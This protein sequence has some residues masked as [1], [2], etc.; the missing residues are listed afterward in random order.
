MSAGRYEQ[1]VA[2]EA[3]AHSS[4]I[5]GHHVAMVSFPYDDTPS[6]WLQYRIVVRNG[7]KIFQKELGVPASA[8]PTPA[9]RLRWAY[10]HNARMGPDC[11]PEGG[12][13]MLQPLRWA[14]HT[15][16]TPAVREPYSTLGC[17]LE[18]K[19]PINVQGAEDYH[20]STES[21]EASATKE[22]MSSKDP[23][24]PGAPPR[25]EAEV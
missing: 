6:P 16:C 13:A 25:L 10:V 20:T 18:G 15:P 7:H 4:A 3:P 14:T 8:P 5:Y 9:Y 12:V 11:H 21:L 1:T 22:F 2:V 19:R 17:R 23:Q 24:L